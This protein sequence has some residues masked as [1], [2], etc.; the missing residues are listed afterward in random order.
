MT[1]QTPARS[2]RRRHGEAP[3]AVVDLIYRF[4]LAN[5]LITNLEI[6]P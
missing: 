3:A 2:D 6:A 5:D 4:S 1:I